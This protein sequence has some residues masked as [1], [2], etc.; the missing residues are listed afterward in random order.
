MSLAGSWLSFEGHFAQ[1]P[2]RRGAELIQPAADD[3]R[4]I[5]MQ[6][7]VSKPVQPGQGYKFGIFAGLHG[8][9]EAGTLA[10]QELVRWAATHPYELSDFELHFYPI[11]NPTGCDGKTRHSAAGLDLNREF[12]TGSTE[13]E[14]IYLERELRR[15]QFHG[16]V[17]LHSDD[18]SHGV[19]GFVS[20]SLLSEELLK[21]ALVKAAEFLPHNF[22]DI[23]DGFQA[24]HGIIREC[25]EGILSAP[26]EQRPRPLEIVFETPALAPL[27][28]QVTA[29]IEA[30]K[31]ILAEYRQLQAYA[32]DL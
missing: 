4:G 14:V 29:T 17:Q 21:P 22:H 31:T 3:P 9:E 18:T 10:T 8:D 25:Y 1:R 19:Y 24:D 13:P 20:G 26:P 11:C 32:A 7:I 6:K 12:W 30:V 5:Y 23:I 15:E 2:F 27:P 28:Q 16:I